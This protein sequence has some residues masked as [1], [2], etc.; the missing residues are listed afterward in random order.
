MKTSTVNMLDAG[1]SQLVAE[2]LKSMFN[3]NGNHFGKSGTSVVVD[4]GTG[5]QPMRIFCTI[6]CNVGGRERIAP[7]VD[8]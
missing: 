4:D 8:V 6:C 7:G 2:I 5:L 3:D 1:M